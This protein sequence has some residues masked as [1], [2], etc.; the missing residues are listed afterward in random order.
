VNKEKSNWIW[1]VLS[2]IYKCAERKKTRIKEKKDIGDEEKK[3]EIGLLIQ[4]LNFHYLCIS[5]FLC[6]LV[7][8]VV[9]I[10]ECQPFKG[11]YNSPYK[12]IYGTLVIVFSWFYL[13][14]RANEIFKAFLNDAV[15][16]L[17]RDESTNSLKYGE[18]L[19]LA[20]NSYIELILL[21]AMVYFLSPSDFF[22]FKESH[23]FHSIFEAI[24]FSGVTITT[25]GYGDI[26]PINLFIQLTTIYEVL[27][28]FSLIIV[29]F[30]VYSNLAIAEQKCNNQKTCGSRFW[31]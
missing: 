16:K 5:I 24:Y 25:L 22:C 23:N 31:R 20:L 26:T 11:W 12:D 17:D 18:R 9:T 13:F 29:S 7:Q 21:F 19:K 4:E 14:S 3:K 15:C 10:G 2:P 28:G 8:L 27:V 6:V 30:A 1:W